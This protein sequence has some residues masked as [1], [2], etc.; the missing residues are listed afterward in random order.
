[1]QIRWDG[2]GLLH[3]IIDINKQAAVLIV[4]IMFIIT[5]KSESHLCGKS[6]EIRNRKS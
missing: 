2:S 6:Q 3:L 1:M 4:L 5:S